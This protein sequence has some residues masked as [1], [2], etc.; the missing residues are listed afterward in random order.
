M[1]YDWIC[2]YR[3]TVQLSLDM[4][5]SG[6]MGIFFLLSWSFIPQASAVDP[7]R[8]DGSGLGPVSLIEG[9]GNQAVY[10]GWY[11]STGL[12]TPGNSN[13]LTG[14]FLALQYHSFFIFDLAGFSGQAYDSATLRFYMPVDGVGLAEPTRMFELYDVITPAVDL[15][16]GAGGVAAFQ[17]LGS[18]VLLGATV[19]SESDEGT[20]VDVA[21]NAKGVLALNQALNGDGL[22]VVG[23]R[24]AVPPGSEE[25]I[26]ALTNLGSEVTSIRL[27]QST[28]VPTL[29]TWGLILLSLLLLIF[30]A[31]QS[32]LKKSPI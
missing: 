24:L 6:V 28:P 25:F 16:S 14:S 3:S 29:G 15:M 7:S 1:R 12:H 23:G 13:Y 30:G 11:Q 18:G 5:E 32:R 26:F 31:H 4:S 2:K 22:F 17:D 19:I 10:R 27:G 9:A 8:L 21:L 20:L